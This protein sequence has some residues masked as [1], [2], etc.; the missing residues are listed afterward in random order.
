MIG[1]CDCCDRQNVPV[2]NLVAYGI[3]TTACFICRGG[4]EVDPYGELD[5]APALSSTDH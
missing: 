3:D 2:S 1:S 4:D 5:E